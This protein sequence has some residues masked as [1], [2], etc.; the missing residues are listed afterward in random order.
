MTMA[1]M[2]GMRRAVTKFGQ[3]RI[4]REVAGRARNFVPK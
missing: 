2:N 4:R 1:G 3:V